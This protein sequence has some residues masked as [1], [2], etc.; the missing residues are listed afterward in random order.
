MAAGI[1][2]LEVDG[3]RITVERKAIRNLYL[4]VKP[5]GIRLTAPRTADDA[6]LRRF[7]R[8][9]WDWLDAHGTQ[10]QTYVPR[11][12]DGERFPLWGAHVPLEVE[13]VRGKPRFVFTGGVLRLYRGAEA[14]AAACQ[15]ALLSFYRAQLD[16]ALPAVAAERE[17]LMGLH[18]RSWRLRDMSSRWGSCTVKTGDIRLNV[19]L[20][21]FPPACLAYLVTHELAHL[22]IPG[23]GP[24]FY[25]LVERYD[26]RW[27]E[28]KALLR[29]GM[30]VLPP[31]GS[32]ADIFCSEAKTQ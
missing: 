11:F 5:D 22:E 30:E 3:L 4:R 24:R 8:A 32:A 9:K 12:V 20:A 26:P 13:V 23:H 29:S 19:Q 10:R 2:V 6:Q 31:E 7:V 17:A 28:A 27:R 18:A 21:K 1:S 16:A 14:D 15:A 25:D